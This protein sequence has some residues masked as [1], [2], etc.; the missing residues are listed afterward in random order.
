MKNPVQKIKITNPRTGRVNEVRAWI[1]DFSDA[2]A[3]YSVEIGVVYPEAILDAL[4]A[5]MNLGSTS[6]LTELRMRRV[7][8]E[9]FKEAYKA[10]A[11][12]LPV[13]KFR[14][15][16]TKEHEVFLLTPTDPARVV[17]ELEPTRV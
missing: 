6:Q 16:V 7:A 5:S 13:S 17:R 3:V 12:A 4:F 10:S 14:V 1:I 2:N 15:C 11:P 9:Q 8:W